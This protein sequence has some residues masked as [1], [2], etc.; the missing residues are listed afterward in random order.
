MIRDGINQGYKTASHPTIFHELINS[1][2]PEEEKTDAR[3]GDEAQ[4]IVCAGIITTSW[5][6]SL[7]AF[8]LSR[9]PTI[10]VRLREEIEA[11]GGPD[12]DWRHLEKIP[13]LNA[14]VHESIRLSHG[15]VTRDPRLAPDEELTYG[16]WTIPRNTAVS[17][18]TVDVLMNEEIFTDPRAFAPDRW[19]ENPG[20]EK[21]FVP[22][23]K[24]TRQ[25]LGIK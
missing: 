19:I 12:Q 22:F 9:S 18:T 17:M 24:G 10:A 3:L 8:H 23:G 20:L 11:S 4:L 13:Y 15:I 7:A 21:Y 16:K 5:A 25:C 2:L 14:V 1:D 6:L